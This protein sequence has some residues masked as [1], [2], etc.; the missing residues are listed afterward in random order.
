VVPFV[1]APAVVGAVTAPVVALL[2]V[3]PDEPFC[4][5]ANV[6]DKPSVVAKAKVENFIAVTFAIK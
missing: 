6:L 2:R 5:N 1:A 3:E 4:A